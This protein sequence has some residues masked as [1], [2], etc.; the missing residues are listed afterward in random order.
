MEQEYNKEII[1]L[2]VARL[3][4]L[5]EGVGVSIGSEG[6][7]SKEDLILHVQHN[8][9]VGKKIIDAEMSF[10]RALKDKNFY[11]DLVGNFA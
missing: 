4:T 2:V 7:F 1:D 9:S 11:G 6:E 3:Q 10:L 5:P 8:D